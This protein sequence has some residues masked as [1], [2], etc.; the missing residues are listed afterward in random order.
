MNTDEPG[1]AVAQPQFRPFVVR[2]STDECSFRSQFRRC[3][4][5]SEI[6]IAIAMRNHS[7]V[8]TATIKHEY[9]ALVSIGG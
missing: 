9:F 6:A 1:D 8:V 7:T 4:S 2:H 3:L 5:V